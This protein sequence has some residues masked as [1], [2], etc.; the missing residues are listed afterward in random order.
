M[1][2][3]RNKLIAANW[4][5]NPNTRTEAQTL[6]SGVKSGLLGKLKD[7]VQVLFCVPFLYI[8]LVNGELQNTPIKL[9]A[10]NCYAEE[11]GAFTGEV[12]AA[13]LKNSGCDYVIL[14]HSERRTLFD[15]NDDLISLKAQIAHKHSLLPIVCVG[16]TLEQRDSGQTDQTIIAQIKGSLKGLK[17]NGQN[18][19]IAYEPVWAI[20]TGKT[21]SS[22]EANRVCA[23]IRKEVA[24][25]Y[26]PEIAEQTLILYGGSVKSSTV[27]EQMKQT[28]I[29]GALVGGA[30][31]LV[32]E[33]VQLV[34]N[35]A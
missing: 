11:K 28:D 32:D 33:F 25:L 23:L 17:L 2:H 7:S 10:Q 21:C 16:E 3:K 14:G 34:M 1:T 15:E 20:G 6:A 24:K 5:M 9:G 12:S 19:V 29:D 27:A 22:E 8:D 18:L 13:M 35:A 31:L 30:S 4:K 26:S